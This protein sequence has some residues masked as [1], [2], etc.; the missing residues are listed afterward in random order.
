MKPKQFSLLEPNRVM[1]MEQYNKQKAQR[2]A[3][4]LYNIEHGLC[5]QCS[6]LAIK[7]QQHCSECRNKRMAYQKTI[8]KFSKQKAYNK[9][10]QSNSLKFRDYYYKKHYGITLEDYDNLL[11]EQNNKCA[12]CNKESNKRLLIDHSHE[13]NKIR[14][15]LC[16]NCNV[17]LGHAFENIEVLEK[18][19]DYIKKWRMI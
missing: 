17:L 18:T 7:G 6:K 16:R 13:T 11:K 14:G 5:L 10:Y 12:I 8:S 3:H 1:T 4:R 15:L 2:K 19:I 9:Y